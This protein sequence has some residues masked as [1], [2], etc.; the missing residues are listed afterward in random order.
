MATTPNFIGTPTPA[1]VNVATANT[2]IDG[3]GAITTLIAGVAAG[4][5]ILEIDA[6]VALTGA[7]AAALVNIFRSYDTGSTW[8]LYDQIA[9]TA[10]T[11]SAT[12]KANRNVLTPANLVIIGTNELIGVT[13]TVSQSTNVHVEASSL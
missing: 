3:T 5:R 10:A 1:A 13:T 7:A 8:K 6:Q 11:A 4:T 9:I 12:V 2:A